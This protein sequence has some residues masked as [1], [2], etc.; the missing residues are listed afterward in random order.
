L[1]EPG[2]MKR[3]RHYTPPPGINSK[4]EYYRLARNLELGNT[5]AQWEYKHF[6]DIVELPFAWEEFASLPK[7]VALRG[8]TPA[9]SVVQAYDLTPV[10][11]FERGQDA[12]D[13]GINPEHILVDE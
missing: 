3:L 11:A 1:E 4:P 2:A 9:S 8:M 7:K 5:I 13:R 6:A 10:E 12:M